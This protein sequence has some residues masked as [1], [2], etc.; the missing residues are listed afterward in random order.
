MNRRPL[1]VT[2]VACVY[3]A[4]GALG[5][6]FHLAD[7]KQHPFPYDAVLVEIISLIAVV[8]GAY[9]LLGRNWARWLALAWIAF[10]VVVSAFHSLREFAIH[11]M[12][13][14]VIAYL[15]FRPPSA[16]YFRHAKRAAA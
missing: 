10:H 15:L 12:F 4:T 9:L 7:F 16:R 6:A 5:V 13:C 8:S 11:L 3:L 1:S 14:A 2:I